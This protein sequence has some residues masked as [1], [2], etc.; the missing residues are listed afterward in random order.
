MIFRKVVE[1]AALRISD[2]LDTLPKQAYRSSAKKS[3]RP[4]SRYKVV[5]SFSSLSPLRRAVGQRLLQDR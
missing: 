4:E 3:R 1:I 5:L 2:D